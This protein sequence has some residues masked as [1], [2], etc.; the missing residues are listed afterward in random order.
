MFCYGNVTM[1]Q[2]VPSGHT[3][4]A[5]LNRHAAWDGPFVERR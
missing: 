2:A 5:V 1:K 4:E 3:K